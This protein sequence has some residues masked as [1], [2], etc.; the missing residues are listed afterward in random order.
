MKRH[1]A[2]ECR[3]N[4]EVITPETAQCQICGQTYKR[5]RNYGKEGWQVKEGDDRLYEYIKTQLR[6]SLD[7]INRR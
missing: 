5:S 3:D 2:K 7:I 4:V 1:T 6:L